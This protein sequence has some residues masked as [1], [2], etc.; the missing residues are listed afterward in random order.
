MHAGR[1]TPTLSYSVTP[2]VR[3]VAARSRSRVVLCVTSPRRAA[4]GAARRQPQRG[5]T[6]RFFA[7]T[8]LLHAVD[9]C[10]EV[11]FFFFLVDEEEGIRAFFHALYF[12]TK[13]CDCAIVYCSVC[14]C[15][16]VCISVS[17]CVTSEEVATTI[18]CGSKSSARPSGF[19]STGRGD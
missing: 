7:I 2:Q 14:V 15:A 6:A 3:S 8:W 10:L 13:L 5:A 1:G 11:F 12:P 17:A 18:V 16:C 9:S 4:N 19:H